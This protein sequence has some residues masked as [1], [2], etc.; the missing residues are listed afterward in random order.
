LNHSRDRDSVGGHTRSTARS[1]GAA[2]NEPTSFLGSITTADWSPARR[3]SALTIS[4]EAVGTI[5]GRVVRAVRR[6]DPWRFDGLVARP[7]AAR[8]EVGWVCPTRSTRFTPRGR[9]IFRYVPVIR[10]HSRAVPEVHDRWVLVAEGGSSHGQ[11]PP[12]S[13]RAV[14]CRLSTVDLLGSGVRSKLN[15]MPGTLPIVD[16]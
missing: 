11:G 10:L 8:G 13:V 5:I 15:R 9:R 6:I 1:V 3:R 7:W 16:S 2:G 4:W 14:D 12:P